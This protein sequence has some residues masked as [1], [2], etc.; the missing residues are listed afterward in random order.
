MQRAAKEGSWDVEDGDLKVVL[1]CK[2]N[3]KP[4]R[5]KIND[6]R[7][8]LIISPRQWDITAADKL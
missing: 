7:A 1:G 5:G 4:N 2:G 6:W 3:G 8:N